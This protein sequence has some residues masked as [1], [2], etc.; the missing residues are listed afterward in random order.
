M[1]D[2]PLPKADAQTAP[3][4]A[5][6]A[7]GTLKYQ[8]CESCGT[9]QFTPRASCMQCHDLRLAWEDS[10]RYGTILSYTLVHRAPVIAFK[11]KTPYVIAIVDM[12]EGFRLMAN[13]SEAVAQDL[14]I[15]SRVRIGFTQVNDV[16]LPIVEA[17]A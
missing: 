11:A 5:G 13:T 16:A 9:V 4:W 17:L 3:F 12:D 6:C 1:I 7:Q 8:R 2:Y 14:Q 10:S 15:N